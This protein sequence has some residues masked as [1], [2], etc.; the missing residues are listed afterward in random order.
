MAGIVSGIQIFPFR[1]NSLALPILGT[2]IA[3]FFENICKFEK[4]SLDSHV[5]L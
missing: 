3:T 2:E 4:I 1:L 5:N